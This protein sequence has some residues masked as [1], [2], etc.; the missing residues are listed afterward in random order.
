[1]NS[2]NI[3]D[4]KNNLSRYLAR[5]RQGAELT[6]LDRDTP[7]ARILPF[8]PRP[9]AGAR[10]AGATNA[11]REAARARIEELQR[12]GILGPGDPHGLTELARTHPPVKLPKGTP[13]AVD[14]LIKMRRESTR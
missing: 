9:V 6:V 4:L 13:S 2:V 8:A 12:L 5:V 10:D 11:E 3:A 7:I 1:M 14:I